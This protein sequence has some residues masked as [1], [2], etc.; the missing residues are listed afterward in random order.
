MAS[1]NATTSYTFTNTGTVVGGFAR[2]RI[3]AASQ[4]SV[5]GAVNINGDQFI[6]GTEMYMTIQ[7]NGSATEFWFESI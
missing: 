1:P 2:L 6:A 4:P 5:T 7:Y 3:N